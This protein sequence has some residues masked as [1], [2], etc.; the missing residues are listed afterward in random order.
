[1]SSRTEQKRTQLD[2]RKRLQ[3]VSEI[4]GYAAE[5]EE[6]W[7]YYLKIK[8]LIGMLHEEIPGNS[9]AER[10]HN[11]RVICAVFMARLSYDSM[12]K[13]KAKAEALGEELNNK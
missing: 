5:S 4:T 9:L 1:M 11:L 13:L 7:Q 10:L 12:S 8:S 2:L 6:N 3:L